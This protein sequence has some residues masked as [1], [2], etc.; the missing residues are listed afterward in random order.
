MT[1]EQDIL[2]IETSNLLLILWNNSN[3]WS[4]LLIQSVFLGF[5]FFYIKKLSK[6]NLFFFQNNSEAGI[7]IWQL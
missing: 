6:K 5:V 2:L 1:P 3:R 7:N 4:H